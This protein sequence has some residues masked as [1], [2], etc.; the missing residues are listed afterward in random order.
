MSFGNYARY[1]LNFASLAGYREQGCHPQGNPE[2]Y[3]KFR[4]IK[5]YPQK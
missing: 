5:L 2:I 1:L 4:A 3:S